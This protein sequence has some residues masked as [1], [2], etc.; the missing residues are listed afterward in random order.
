MALTDIEKVRLL[1]G[2][3]PTSP[4]YM[5]FSDDE[6]QCFLDMAGGSVILAAR[7][8]AISASFQIA[9]WSS[10]ERT[11]D[12]EVWSNLSTAYLRALDNFIKDASANTLP[13]GIMP[14]AAGISY[15]DICANNLNT[16]NVRSPLAGIRLCGDNTFSYTSFRLNNCC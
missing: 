12:I 6:I 14:Y 11:G 2:D 10:R 15:D 5:L 1:I 7:T 4:F 9:G 3:T 8:A 16:D 13:N